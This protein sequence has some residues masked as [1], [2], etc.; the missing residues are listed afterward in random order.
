MK[1]L[2]LPFYILIYAIY[3]LAM[4]AFFALALQALNLSNGWSLMLPWTILYSYL[5]EKISQ[6]GPKPRKTPFTKVSSLPARHK[7][8]FWGISFG[9]STISIFLGLL[10][11][12]LNSILSAILVLVI[13]L[14][15]YGLLWISSPVLREELF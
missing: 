4:L 9:L 10:L 1:R 8:I 7:F 14:V 12:S 5:D 6:L 13:L 11:K 3:F 15:W 2:S